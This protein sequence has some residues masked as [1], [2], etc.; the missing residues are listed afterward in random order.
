MMPNPQMTRKIIT[1]NDNVCS[2]DSTIFFPV[3]GDDGMTYFSP[4]FAGCTNQTLS[5]YGGCS[6]VTSGQTT[7][8]MCVSDCPYFYYY[9]AVDAIQKLLLAI[10]VLLIYLTQLRSVESK[11]KAIAFGLFSFLA[12]LLV[13]E[14]IDGLPLKINPFAVS[15]AVEAKIMTARTAL[16]ISD[17]QT[18]MK[19]RKHSRKKESKA[20][21]PLD[22]PVSNPVEVHN[23]YESLDMEVSPSLS[24]QRK[25]PQPRTRSPIEPP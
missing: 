24:V 16:E 7:A 18:A 25:G 15:K 12:S 5:M 22:V 17:V 13:V 3:C 14:G 6:K 1:F 8:G 11:D 21:K 2:C 10:S 4:C 9:I 20:L 23:S 19:K